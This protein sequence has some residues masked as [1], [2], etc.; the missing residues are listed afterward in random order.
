MSPSP[1]AAPETSLSDALAQGWTVY[2]TDPRE[3]V[4]IADRVTQ[5]ATSAEVRDEAGLLRGCGLALLGEF[6][7]AIE[8]LASRPELQE[9]YPEPHQVRR[10]LLALGIAEFR[11]GDTAR[12]FELWERGREASAR[13]GD[14][15]LEG[16]ALLQ[17]GI[18]L[19]EQG[20]AP[21]A[22]DR[23]MHALEIFERLA[24]ARGIA[25]AR[26][27]LGN[28]LLHIGEY[29][30]AA[31]HHLAALAVMEAAGERRGV[32]VGR[33]SLG[34]VQMKLGNHVDAEASLRSAAEQF[35]E[36]G[37]RLEEAI[38]LCHLGECVLQLGRAAEA[39]SHLRAA[40]ALSEATGSLRYT[41]IARV[42]C[43][44]ALAEAGDCSSA[45]ELLRQTIE[46]T[47][48]ADR[49]PL[50]VEALMSA[51]RLRARRPDEPAWG[52]LPDQVEALLE[53]TRTGTVASMLSEAHGTLAESFESRGELARA[54]THYKEHLR[55]VR[56]EADERSQR[57]VA[58]TEV[59]LTVE[60]LRRENETTAANNRRLAEALEEAR[61]ERARAE[62]A[63][64]AKS[65]LLG[66]VA[67]DLRNPLAYIA[68]AAEDVVH[69]SDSVRVR[70]ELT[71][72]GRTAHRASRLIR[73]LVDGAAADENQ[74]R[75][76]VEDIDLAAVVSGLCRQLELF[77][78][79]KQQVLRVLAPTPVRARADAQ[80]I[81]QV[82]QNLVD[83]AIKFS[84]RGAAT[85]V[86][87]AGRAGRAVL[88][89]RDQ[90]PGMTP[91]DLA[92]AFAP[93]AERS[94]TPT[95]GEISTGIGLSITRQ[96]VEAMGGTITVQSEGLGRGC[97]FTVDLPLA[98]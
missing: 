45:A 73:S 16:N 3:A 12:A 29:N 9:R 6:T 83:N 36:L 2:V 38:A 41:V 97:V 53:V 40:A 62:A 32:A 84:P 70:T 1:Q 90:G 28:V 26:G 48:A 55:F 10:A 49:A 54:I 33:G 68:L 52:A 72:I 94:A 5:L 42:R 74:L 43:A 30:R 98:G 65:A 17:M 63:S 61:R 13:A 77:A 82:V 11:G 4:R 71:G 91:A 86:S 60:R 57:A 51:A 35:Q 58:R 95:A 27:N 76:R 20:K 96:L 75:V 89:V 24:H 69:E 23:L 92:S 46:M 85:E 87:V 44:E 88:V 8:A 15:N 59:E 14:P 80:R 56:L 50:R 67:H 21:Q 81:E 34:W 64:R 93:F 66:I 31:E 25:V 47:T 79:E 7:R 22:V 18:G 39:A 78:R 19:T 37:L